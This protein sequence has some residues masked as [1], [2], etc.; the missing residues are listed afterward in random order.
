MFPL[1]S[2][3]D[4]GPH[5]PAGAQPRACIRPGVSAEAPVKRAVHPFSAE[6]TSKE[7]SSLLL[8]PQPNRT[9]F[10][11]HGNSPPQGRCTQPARVTIV[12]GQGAVGPRGWEKPRLL[13]DRGELRGGGDAGAR[14]VQGTALQAEGTAGGKRGGLKVCRLLGEASKQLKAHGYLGSWVGSGEDLPTLWR[15]H[16]HC[17][18]LGMKKYMDLCWFCV[19][20]DLSHN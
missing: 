12:P 7:H 16:G 20:F 15:S 9:Q 19:T 8:S 6:Q 3:K 1:L 2:N 11:P 10:L 13:E 5:F 14:T 17:V 18:P 4:V